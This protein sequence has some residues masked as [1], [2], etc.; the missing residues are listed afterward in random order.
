MDDA[1]IRALQETDP[2]RWAQLVD[3]ERRQRSEARSP[4]P[5]ASTRYATLRGVE[6]ALREV[7]KTFGPLL[8]RLAQVEQRV[9]AVETKAIGVSIRTESVVL[10]GMHAA[11]EAVA[12]LKQ[13]LERPLRPVYNEKGILIGAE[14]AGALPGASNDSASA[15]IEM[16]EKRV[17]ALEVELAAR[18]AARDAR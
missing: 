2:E 16:L 18:Q 1:E 8:K 6:N 10:D 5:E 14:R 13:T 12:S 11:A 4:Q 17:R 9:A 7:A 3:P 15:K